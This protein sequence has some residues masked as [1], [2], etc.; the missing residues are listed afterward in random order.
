MKTPVSRTPPIETTFRSAAPFGPGG[1]EGDN[2]PLK[3][4]HG[5]EQPETPAGAGDN[6]L[7]DK[8]KGATRP[9]RERPRI[10]RDPFLTAV[11]PYLDS[12]RPYYNPGTVMRIERNFRTVNRDLWA[13]RRSKKIAVVKPAALTEHEIGAL[14]LRWR[15]RGLDPGY[16]RRL[17]GVLEPFLSYCGNATLAKLRLD[18]RL[19]LMR[20]VE[21]PIDVLSPADLDRLRRAAEA[22]PAWDGIVARFLVAFLPATGLRPKEIRLA[23]VADVDMKRWRILVSHP[24][25]EGS[26]AAPDYAP[27]LPSAREATVDFFLDRT[28]YLDRTVCEWLVPYRRVS[29]EIGPWSEPLLRKLKAELARASGVEF[30]L[31]T[32]RATFAQQVKDAGVHIEA[33]SRAL[34]HKSTNT[35][36]AYYARLRADDAFRQ[37]EEAFAVVRVAENP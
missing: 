11:R 10:V 17:L 21:K 14:L 29:S 32:F 9:Y 19:R 30:H 18:P 5:C 25:G 22:L 7:G 6:P 36:E 35:T 12:I 26:W 16:Q 33:V 1:E 15:E 34:R 20:S 2:S 27:I 37:I 31:K 3:A 8:T 23:R 13:L 4:Q 28:D 24:K